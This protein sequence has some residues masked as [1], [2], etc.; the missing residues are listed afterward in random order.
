MPDR[1]AV[2]G[3]PIAHSRSPV[4]HAAFAEQTGQSLDYTAILGDHADFERT[5]AQLHADGL[6]GLNVTLPFKERALALAHHCTERAVRAGAAN[7]LSFA[8]GQISADNTDGAGFMRDLTQG[9]GVRP[10]GQRVLVLGAGGAVRGIL[11]PLLDARPRR[12]DFSNRTPARAQT[13]RDAVLAE[14]G[15]AGS[16]GSAQ[17]HTECAVLA[18]GSLRDAGP[19]DLVVNG[20]SGG[21]AGVA[22]ELAR[23]LFAPA[24]LA[25]DLSYRLEGDTPFLASARAAGAARLADGLGMLVEQAAEAFFVWRGI[26]PE[27]ARVLSDLRAGS[28]GVA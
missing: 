8:H 24:A 28:A 23:S 21:W 7:T 16:G 6:L 5:V 26:W 9:L 3:A 1:Y 4:I 27:T 13:L 2:I 22:P 19:Y 25:Y 20:T 15:Q 12:I 18:A 10:E 11:G 14:Q 17:G